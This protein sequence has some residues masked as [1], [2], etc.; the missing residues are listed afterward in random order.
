[1]ALLMGMEMEKVRKMRR[2]MRRSPT[3]KAM[4]KTKKSKRT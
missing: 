1:M 4:R 2:K 3:W